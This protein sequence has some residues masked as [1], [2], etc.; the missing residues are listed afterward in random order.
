MAKKKAGT[1][2]DGEPKGKPGPKPK[3]LVRFQCPANTGNISISREHG[4][5]VYHPDENGIVDV[6]P[7]DAQAMMESHF[8]RIGDVR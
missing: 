6:E 7:R 5:K 3:P 8:Q 1:K 4:T 2:K